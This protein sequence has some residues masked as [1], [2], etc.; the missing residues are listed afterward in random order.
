[1]FI[2]EYLVYFAVTRYRLDNQGVG[3]QAPVGLR[4]FPFPH[5]LDW[6][7]GPLSLLHDGHQAF[8]LQVQSGRCIKLTTHLKLVLR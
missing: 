8:F 7:W 3:I 5:H 4:I 1:M 2:S 6:L